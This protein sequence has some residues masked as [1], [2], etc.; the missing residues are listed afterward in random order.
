MTET[1]ASGAQVPCISL[2]ADLRAEMENWNN[3]ADIEKSPLGGNV[4]KEALYRGT[5]TGLLIAVN[6]I[7]DNAPRQ[8]RSEATYP[9]RLI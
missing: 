7:E 1:N 9:E 6:M 3:M 2:L 8:D 5:A 4:V